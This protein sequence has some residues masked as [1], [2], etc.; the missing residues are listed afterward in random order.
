M[1]TLVARITSLRL[2]D[3]ASHFPSIVSDS[4]PVCPGAQREYTSAVSMK[5]RPESNAASS[6]RNEAGSSSVQ[7]KTF[8]PRQIAGTSGPAF[9]SLRVFI[10][11][12]PH[13]MGCASAAKNHGLL[14]GLIRSLSGGRSILFQIL[15]ERRVNVALHNRV[16]SDARLRI[17]VV[18]PQHRTRVLDPRRHALS[19]AIIHHGPHLSERGDLL[20][21]HVVGHSARAV[22]PAERIAVL[23]QI[24]LQ[25]IQ[26]FFG[27]GIQ[28]VKLPPQ[29]A[30]EDR[31]L[32]V[33]ATGDDL[34]TIYPIRGGH[35][36]AIQLR[37]PV[38]IN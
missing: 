38:A 6:T 8:P 20:F 33:S 4:P 15:V 24:H 14:I 22:A 16:R 17:R 32:L 18:P 29:L 13:R 25:R 2:P 12:S 26:L 36:I 27:A 23:H 3:W 30:F 28:R 7:P 10:C 21:R 9:P 1:P 5:R 11:N 31:R 19:A 37:L 35:I 34:P